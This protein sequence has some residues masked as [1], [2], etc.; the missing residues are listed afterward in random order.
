MNILSKKKQGNTDLEGNQSR[1]FLM[2]VDRLEAML[3]MES[4]SVVVV[5]IPFIE[6]LKAFNSVVHSCFGVALLEDYKDNIARFSKLYR[7]L[8]ISVTPKV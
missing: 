5:A 8:D 1:A 2:C 4:S 3:M 7:D 6:T